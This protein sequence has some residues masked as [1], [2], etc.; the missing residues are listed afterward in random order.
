MTISNEV[1]S[2]VV[3][4]LLHAVADF[5]LVGNKD[6]KAPIV[7]RIKNNSAEW[8]T[9][10]NKQPT[11]V[12]VA[13]GLKLWDPKKPEEKVEFLLEPVSKDG[14][15][16]MDES[17]ICVSRYLGG[18]AGDAA[19]PL[20]GSIVRALGGA[21]LGFTFGLGALGKFSFGDNETLTK[22]IDAFV[23]TLATRVTGTAVEHVLYGPPPTDPE[24]QALVDLAKWVSKC[25]QDDPS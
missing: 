6:I 22:L 10:D 2:S 8:I 4:I 19:Q 9:K 7:Y 20:T 24:L 21:N 3:T 14:K 16:G 25:K 18:A 11:F 1:I 23:Q 12:D 15:D 5:S 13:I 17:R